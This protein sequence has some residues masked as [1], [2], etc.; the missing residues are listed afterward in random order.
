VL[1]DIVWLPALSTLRLGTGLARDSTPCECVPSREAIAAG[2][3][4][5]VEDRKGLQP[6]Q[7]SQTAQQGPPHLNSK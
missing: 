1:Q 6:W 3:V 7:P 2:T 4:R 5:Q